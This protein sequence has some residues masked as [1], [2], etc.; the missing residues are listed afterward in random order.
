LG[1]SRLDLG[2]R[3]LYPLPI[4]RSLL[5]GRR[6]RQGTGQRVKDAE[7]RERPEMIEIIDHPPEQALQ[8]TRRHYVTDPTRHQSSRRLKGEETARRSRQWPAYAV[9]TAGDEIRF[10][11]SEFTA[12]PRVQFIDPVSVT[13]SSITI[14]AIR[15]W[16]SI[17]IGTP[18]AAKGSIPLSRSQG[19]VAI[20]LTSWP[21]LL[22]P[23]QCLDD[24]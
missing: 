14:V 20:N 9:A 13:A 4:T 10:R 19:V 21:R 16:A 5:I 6:L 3:S 23:D 11:S 15:A 1:S 22:G 18:A 17:Q 8:P 2:K 7:R 24:A 12:A